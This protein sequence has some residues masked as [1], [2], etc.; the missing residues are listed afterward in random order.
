MRLNFNYIIVDD[1]LDENEWRVE[2]L[3]ELADKKI[4]SKGF[5]PKSE[6]YESISEFKEQIPKEKRKR[7]DLYLSDN[8]LGD[9]TENNNHKNDGI[10]LYLELH[11]EF[12]CD[13]VLYTGSSQEEIVN[14]LKQELE[15]TQNPN[16]FSRFTF[17][18]RS[19]DE[20]DQWHQPILDLIDHIISKRE[21]MNNLRGLYAQSVS[22]ID[23]HLKE[24]FNRPD[25]E[26]LYDTIEAIDNKFF[27]KN[28][29][30]DQLHHIRNIR[31]GLLHNDEEFDPNQK[32]YIVYYEKTE[33]SKKSG[34]IKETELPKYRKWI[35]EAHD[36]VLNWQTVDVRRDGSKFYIT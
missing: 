35:N 22:R 13:F 14:K 33:G 31:N 5:N 9:A 10:K 20:N 19:S 17:V 7:Y 36:T 18:T 2:A 34:I 28:F 16:L 4:E 21:E 3:R 23:K 15:K 8:N 12:I 32:C 26:K 29:K 1:D 25:N 6:M 27:D 24:I 11:K 30:R